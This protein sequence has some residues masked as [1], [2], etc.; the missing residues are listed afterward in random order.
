MIA[1]LAAVVIAG[2]L[3]AAPAA[4]VENYIA[5]GHP[6]APGD[7][8]LPP[9]NSDQDQINLQTDLYEAELYV[10]QRERKA[11]ESELFRFRNDRSFSGPDYSLEY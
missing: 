6:Y 3:A 5:R 8:R 2:L 4:A 1:R 11:M 10:R 9:L 7:D